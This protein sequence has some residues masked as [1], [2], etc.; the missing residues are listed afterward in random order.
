[1]EPTEEKLAVVTR[2]QQ[3]SN[4]IIEKTLLEQCLQAYESDPSYSEQGMQTNRDRANLEQ[5]DGLW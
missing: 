1:M 2:Q 5:R 3:K 4:I